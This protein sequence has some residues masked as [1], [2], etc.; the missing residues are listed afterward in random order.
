MSD[1]GLSHP[2]AVAVTRSN[3]PLWV[4]FAKKQTTGG[5]T[6]RFVTRAGGEWSFALL[7]RSV[8][9]TSLVNAVRGRR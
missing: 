1:Y 5:D 7:S 3:S 2:Y 8:W 9:S 6:P 4:S